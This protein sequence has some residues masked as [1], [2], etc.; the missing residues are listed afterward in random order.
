MSGGN[1]TACRAQGAAPLQERQ[2]RLTRTQVRLCQ[3]QSFVP[4]PLASGVSQFGVSQFAE[5][6]YPDHYHQ[7]ALNHRLNSQPRK[8]P[9]FRPGLYPE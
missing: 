1:A 8:S 5:S 4:L 9:S 3:A 6:K 2:C 7:S